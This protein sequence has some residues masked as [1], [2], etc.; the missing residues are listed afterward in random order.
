M[1]RILAII[2]LRVTLMSRQM[3]GKGGKLNLIGA[4]L[5]LIIG[6]LFALGMAVG[7]GI[8][9][10]LV[11][12]DGDPGKIRIGFLVVFYASLFPNT[13]PHRGEA[14]RHRCDPGHRR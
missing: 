12:R 9:L 10:Y 2:R 11:G 4:I 8:M 3:Q 1:D 6:V 5:L 7:F 14:E 13:S